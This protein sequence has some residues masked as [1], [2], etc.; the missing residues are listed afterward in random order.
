[1]LFLSVVFMACSHKNMVSKKYPF[2]CFVRIKI[3]TT[4]K[5]YTVG[6]FFCDDNT[7]VRKDESCLNKK[8][9][10]VLLYGGYKQT[11]LG[12]STRDVMVVRIGEIEKIKAVKI[13]KRK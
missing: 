8:I 12:D 1:L 3:D 5:K 6:G 10:I 7:Y 13:K 2:G 4:E 9:N 11:V